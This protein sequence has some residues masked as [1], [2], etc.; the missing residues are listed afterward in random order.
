MSLLFSK[1]RNQDQR[2]D[3]SG[4]WKQKE[5]A[6]TLKRNAPLHPT[7]PRPCTSSAREDEPCTTEQVRSKQDR[8]DL[9]KQVSLAPS[10]SGG[11]D[12]TAGSSAVAEKAKSQPAEATTHEAARDLRDPSRLAEAFQI[13]I[14]IASRATITLDVKPGDIIK[15]IKAKI[16]DKEGLAQHMLYVRFAG[17]A[18]FRHVTIPKASLHPSLLLAPS[19]S[20]SEGQGGDQRVQVLVS[21]AAQSA[22]RRRTEGAQRWRGAHWQVLAFQIFVKLA[23]SNKTITGLPLLPPLSP[24]DA[25]RLLASVML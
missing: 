20:V 2:T 6:K 11:Q 17:K 14:K 8:A 24:L 22:F 16:Q 5:K 21:C 1:G 3:T 23:S 12:A 19:S 15:A 18:L 10:S 13:L 7:P 9:E 4:A 25:L